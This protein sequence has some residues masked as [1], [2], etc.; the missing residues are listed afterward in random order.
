[1]ILD[2]EKDRHKA[3]LK[4]YLHLFCLRSSIYVV[5]LYPYPLLLK[6]F[7]NYWKSSNQNPKKIF[8]LFYFIFYK[9][10]VKK[11]DR[12]N[13]DEDKVEFIHVYEWQRKKNEIMHFNVEPK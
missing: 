1:M 7:G 13:Y 3:T 5:N 8:I 12:K 6:N 2:T 4:T 10:K 9:R 11:I